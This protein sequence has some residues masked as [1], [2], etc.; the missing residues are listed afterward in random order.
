MGEQPRIKKERNV[1]DNGSNRKKK[2]WRV[3]DVMLIE[4]RSEK[5]RERPKD[6]KRR[7]NK[8]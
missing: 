2:I 1:G 3:S 7:S 8:M 5:K 6:K 4:R